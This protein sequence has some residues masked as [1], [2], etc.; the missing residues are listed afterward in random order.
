MEYA[1]LEQI[2]IGATIH[3]S[4]DEFQPIHISF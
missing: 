3:T 1:K 2:D 4:F